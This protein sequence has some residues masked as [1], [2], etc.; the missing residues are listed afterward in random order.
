MSREMQDGVCLSLKMA[1]V[2]TGSDVKKQTKTRKQ[3]QAMNDYSIF[4]LINRGKIV[5]H[6]Q[7]SG[8]YKDSNSNLHL[9][10]GVYQHFPQAF[11]P[12]LP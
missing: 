3:D 9:C 7:K 11:L 12:Y 2:G 8:K 10:S 4:T 5:R 6:H 1:C